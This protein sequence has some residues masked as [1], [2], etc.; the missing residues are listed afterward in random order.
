MDYLRGG[1]ELETGR[2]MPFTKRELTFLILIVLMAAFLRLYRLDEVPP[3]LHGDTAYKGVAANRILR[4]EAYPIFF[5]E[6]W[7]GV[8]PMYMYLLALV[9]R[10]AGATPLAIKALSA[11]IGIITVAVFYLL[12]RELFRSVMIGLLASSWLA[13]SYWHVGYSR[14]G[15]EIILAPLFAI[16]T[17]FFF[18]RGLESGRWREFVWAGLAMGASLYTYQAMRFLPI[19]FVSYAGYRTL[20]EK[21]FWKK[22]GLKLGLS[23]CVAVLVF[24]PLGVYFATHSDAFL[25]RAAEVSIFNPEKNPDGPI[26]SFARSAMRILGAYNFRGDPL[27]RHNLPGRPGF[28]LLTSVFFFVGLGVSVGRRKDPA[29]LL[30]LFWLV[31]MSLPPILTPPRDVPHFSRMIGAL[32]AACVFPAIGVHAACRWARTRWP[33]RTASYA[34]A[35][36]VLIMLVTSLAL[37]F[38]DYFMVWAGNG[39]LRD[40]YFDG[41]FLDLGNAMN[42]LDDAEAVWILPISALSSPHDEAGHHTIEFTYRGQAPFHFLNLDEATAAEELS[43]LT[44]GHARALVVK[45][46][47]Y[48]LEEAYNYIDADPKELVPF[49][50]GKYGQQLEQRSFDK[51]DVVTYELPRVPDFVIAGPFETVS[52]DFE[53]Q[54]LL[55]GFDYGLYPEQLERNAEPLGRESLP[56]GGDLWIALRWESLADLPSDYK[57]ALYLLDERERVLGQ[58]DKILLSNHMR[59]TS[60]WEPDQAEIDYY[61]LPSLPATA[62]GDYHIGLVVYDPATMERLVRRDSSGNAVG[63]TFRLV[64]LKVVE[65]P[66]PP[67]V[68][69]Q[70]ELKDADL[71]PEVTLLGYDLPHTQIRP[72]DALEL[73]LYW[74]APRDVQDDYTVQVQLRD[75]LGHVW[76]EEESRPAYGGYPT[77]EWE[78]GEIIRDWHDVP[79]SVEA[80]EGEYHLSVG[81]AKRGVPKGEVRLG[82]IHISGRARSFEIPEMEHQSGWRLGESVILLGY[83]V[84]PTV[85]AGDILELILYWQCVGQMDESYA[86]FT[87]LLDRD[88]G[89][90]GQLDGVPVGSEAPTT[91]W[92]EGEMIADR[93]GIPVDAEA[94]TGEY[95]LEIG[96]YDADTLQ[97]LPAHDP[98]GTPQGDRILLETVL[99]QR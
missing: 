16:V 63:H 89:I 12:V 40:H 72:G 56:S 81:L 64:E 94:A 98:Q 48:A 1:M 55:T 46:K 28:G 26:L 37:T 17:L 67:V 69:P 90:R 45:Y 58:V 20:T 44:R 35:T 19:L 57:V 39:D 14:L 76:A 74:E 25:R 21:G 73:A 31:I 18:W 70:R 59:L 62:P 95:V 13:I 30:L 10:V 22:Y 2:T 65:A 99:V 4:G 97:R 47:N 38:R 53:A 61:I 32:P 42:G 75:D 80:P 92:I 82:T 60:D 83:D 11:V 85:R 23:F 24:A 6:S 84:D 87:H 77:T 41:Q 5:E 68:E 78:R 52:S 33:S 9:F 7:G 34:F 91:S 93:Y 96:M 49:L 3:G 15:W 43:H 29:N 88:S 36:G 86:V 50:L 8:E 66:S 79:V 54:L 71:V 27:W 51:F